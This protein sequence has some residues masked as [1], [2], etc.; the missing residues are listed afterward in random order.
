M[1][2]RHGFCAQKQR[3]QAEGDNGGQKERLQ[4]EGDNGVQKERLQDNGLEFIRAA[5][6]V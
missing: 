3:L 1:P 6:E 2:W 4:A 5:L